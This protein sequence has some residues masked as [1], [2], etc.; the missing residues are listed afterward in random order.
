MH[1][2]EQSSALTTAYPVPLFT[3]EGPDYIF[4]F[5]QHFLLAIAD[6]NVSRHPHQAQREIIDCHYPKDIH[7]VGRLAVVIRNNLHTT[8]ERYSVT[9]LFGSEYLPIGV[10][11]QFNLSA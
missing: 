3:L 11:G 8:W 7:D 4:L 10:Y 9:T 5:N 6:K 2:T 1:Q